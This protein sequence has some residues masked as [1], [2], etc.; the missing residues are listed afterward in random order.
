M[1]SLSAEGQAN[2]SARYDCD[3]SSCRKHSL[4]KNFKAKVLVE[5]EAM[6]N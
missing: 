1:V 5:R 4:G 2:C 3:L 6:I